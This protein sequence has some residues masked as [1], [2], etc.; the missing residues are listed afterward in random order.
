MEN[1]KPQI[2]KMLM[3]RDASIAQYVVDHPEESFGSI[4]GRFGVG[5]NYMT[6]LAKRFKVTRRQGKASPAYPKNPREREK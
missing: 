2:R 6:S 4:A 3:E 1:I 5:G